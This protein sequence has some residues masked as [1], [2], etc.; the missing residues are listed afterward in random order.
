MNRF[1]KNIAV[2]GAGSIGSL[3]ACKL[4][5]AG[6]N[7]FVVCRSP[8]QRH[9]L[10]QNG[11]TLITKHGAEK[12]FLRVLTTDEVVEP[13]HLTIVTVKSYDLKNTIASSHKLLSQSKIIL[14]T[15]S[16]IQT[17]IIEQSPYANK[18][19]WA[20]LMFGATGKGFTLENGPG[21]M[22]IA[23]LINSDDQKDVAPWLKQTLSQIAPT[24]ISNDIFVTLFI[25]V[26]INT[27]L[28][29]LCI[30]GGLS[31]GAVYNNSK[32]IRIASLL[33]RDCVHILAAYKGI[34]CRFAFGYNCSQLLSLSNCGKL[35]RIIA[36]KYSDVIPSTVF[37]I[38]R[39]SQNE[40]PFFFDDLLVL[41]KRNNIPVPF[42]RS[43]SKE[44]NTLIGKGVN[45]NEET[46]NHFAHRI[47]I[48]FNDKP[49]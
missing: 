6:F 49:R 9:Y 34:N 7:I 17:Q 15:E 42:L 1:E 31:F 36:Q 20:S 26:A 13:I 8:E 24:K 14:L 40:L 30:A 43:V 27:V 44:L 38:A 22:E 32:N 33:L 45:L 10:N 48:L 25:K 21:F 39:K 37:D 23:K 2:I 16:T 4:A 5:S 29:P 41:S 18:C 35:I 47:D 46:F 12:E 3:I 11:F 28:F 19:W